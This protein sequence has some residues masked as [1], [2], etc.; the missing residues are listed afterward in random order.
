MRQSKW[1]VS[2][3]VDWESF[4]SGE[5]LTFIKAEHDNLSVQI[6]GQPGFKFEVYGL[7]DEEGKFH[8]LGHSVEVE[9]EGAE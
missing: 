5:S 6:N 9:K 7:L 1:D 2:S 8:M 3:D 4:S